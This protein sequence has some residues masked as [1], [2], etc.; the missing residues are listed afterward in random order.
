M[1]RKNPQP[2]Q[3]LK[4]KAASSPAPEN[5]PIM[6]KRESLSFTTPTSPVVPHDQESSEIVDVIGNEKFFDFEPPL[7][8]NNIKK[9]V[10]TTS[11]KKCPCGKSN[12][13][14]TYI[15][16]SACKQSWHNK[17][18]NCAD[19]DQM[20]I[21]KLVHWECPAC[22]VCPALGK[23]TSPATLHAEIRLM[24]DSIS[25]LT[26]RDSQHTAYLRQ[27]LSQLKEAAAPSKAFDLSSQI[28]MLQREIADLKMSPPRG[29]DELPPSVKAAIE[30]ATK[31]LPEA[32]NTIQESL[33]TL[34]DH[35]SLMTKQNPT[36][37]KN[38]SGI[39]MPNTV[40]PHLAKV[41]TPCKAYESYE[42][43]VL[44]P[45][46]KSELLEFIKAHE[47]E[48]TSADTENSRQLLYFGEYSYK[49]TGSEHPARKPPPILMK[50][51]DSVDPKTGDSRTLKANSCLITRYNSGSS[52]IPMHRDDEA[53]IDPESHILTVS[54]GASRTM[55]FS[56]NDESQVE[57]LRLEDCSLLVTSRYAQDFWRHGIPP[58]EEVTTERVSL[59]FRQIKP[60][61]INSTILLGDSNTS[62]VSF[63]T[64]SGTMGAW[65]PGKR[66][67]VGHIEALPDAVD[68]GPYRNIVIHTGINSLNTRYEKKSDAFLIH[69]LESKCKEYMAVYPRAKI[70]ISTLLPTRLRH[71]NNHVEYFNRAL[72]EMSYKY[73]NIRIIDNSM[74]GDRLSD[75]H[76]RWD[77]IEQRPLVSDTLHLG[78]KGIRL[79]AMN[80]KG[81]IIGKGI[82]QSRA[83]FNSSQGNYSEALSRGRHHSAPKRI[84]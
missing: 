7:T 19:L 37:P 55:R 75:E 70:H 79:F 20:D 22:Y 73:N 23:S 59:T 83:R 36:A 26:L 5:S 62:K 9:P 51:L 47:G 34:A 10:V 1:P 35:V 60:Q 74:F 68:I 45:E 80:I 46:L 28:D 13:A 81:A 84:L 24:R 30:S 43:E 78:R 76:G 6:S 38:Q 66:V 16:C 31:G 67:K 29:E 54:L 82:S 63:G 64:G 3:S 65:V 77:S 39:P 44:P 12:K 33:S 72:V 17:C 42:T 50:V 71:L 4:L 52:H 27:E 41:K 56:N 21:K 49:Y 11:K 57:S 61:F 53:I 69:T 58:E 8:P 2:P 40:S 32:V 18:C 48:F 14:A 15:I 25:A